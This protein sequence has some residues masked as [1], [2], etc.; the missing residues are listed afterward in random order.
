MVLVT[1]F[2][3]SQNV[4][5]VPSAFFQIP[6]QTIGDTSLKILKMIDRED[7][8]VIKL[9]WEYFKWHHWCFASSERYILSCVENLSSFFVQSIKFPVNLELKQIVR[10]WISDSQRKRCVCWNK[11]QNGFKQMSYFCRQLISHS[12]ALVLMTSHELHLQLLSL[13]KIT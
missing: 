7:A 4:I 11:T 12:S 5:I 2:S 3:T 6:W 9:S 13:L 10:L 8:G 1:N